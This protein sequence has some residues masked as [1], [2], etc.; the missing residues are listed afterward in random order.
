MLRGYEVIEQMVTDGPYGVVHKCKKKGTG[1]LVAVK[2]FVTG[3]KNSRDKFQ[4]EVAQLQVS[5]N[6]L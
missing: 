2:Q 1:Q 4:R 3:S 5:P 6:E